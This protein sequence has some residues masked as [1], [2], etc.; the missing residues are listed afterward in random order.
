M[1]Y[2]LIAT[3]VSVLLTLVVRKLAQ[4]LNIFDYPDKERKWHDRLTP[5]L[6]GTA[7]FVS[8]WSV[9]FYVVFIGGVVFISISSVFVITRYENRLGNRLKYDFFTALQGG[10]EDRSGA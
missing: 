3:F 8:F 6:G 5:F 7:I 10:G 1:I 4:K 2:F 9:V